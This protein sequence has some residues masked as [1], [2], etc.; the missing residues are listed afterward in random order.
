MCVLIGTAGC[1]SARIVKNVS[2][3]PL[4]YNY[5]P[6]APS[7][8]HLQRH[9]PH[10]TPD[11]APNDTPADPE[12]T[13]NVQLVMSTATLTKA[14]RALLQDVEGGFNIEYTDPTNKTPRRLTAKEE[15]NQARVKI[16][17][18]EVQSALVPLYPFPSTST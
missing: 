6:F 8:S 17:V 4:P 1:V 18:V 14:V 2:N 16:N 7:T 11:L 10:D 3:R 15:A 13:K 5:I 12:A 9:S